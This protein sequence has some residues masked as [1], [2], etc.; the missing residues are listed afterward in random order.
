MMGNKKL[1]GL[2][3]ALSLVMLGGLLAA[4]NSGGGTAQPAAT[5][6]P[7]AKGAG[8]ADPAKQVSEA[9]AELTF[10]VAINGWTEERFNEAYGSQ[11]KKKFPNYTLKFI[12]QGTAGNKTLEGVITSGQNVDILITSIGLTSSFLTQ[13]D[14]QYDISDLIKKY[15]Y[16]LSRLEPSTIEIQKQLSGNGGIYGLPVST[17]SAALFYNKAI[18][19]KFGVPYPKEG[20]TW[21]ELYDLAKKMTRND[22]GQQYKGMTMSVQHLMLL[23]Q[24]SA[25][26]LEAKTYK[27]QFTTD[28]FR[29]A[30]ENLARFYTIPGNGLVNNKYSKASQEEPFYKDQNVAMYA[31]LSTTGDVFR[32]SIDW[33]MIQLP[34]FKDKPGIGPQS[35][36]NYFYLSK[37]SKN[38][39]AAFQ[40]MAYVTSDEFQEFMNKSGNPSILKDPSKLKSTFAA[41]ASYFKGKNVKSMLPAKFAA[42]TEKSKY[43]TI[44]DTEMQN[45]LVDYATGKKDI[46]SA[47]R[48]AGERVDKAIEAEKKK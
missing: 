13:F 46:N 26:H 30:F 23:N 47:L 15:N 19:D 20:M 48:D 25:P 27:N 39:D 18:F 6:E 43:Q 40:V 16:D 7:Q 29:Q 17:T 9:P 41:D 5:A 12:P 22:G 35:Y 1:K 34:F 33:D 36:P 38:K 10:Y 11:I 2:P 44:A 3:V 21:D 24:L 32:E 31:A 8:A 45:A 14:M 37:A 28:V 4:C 42:P